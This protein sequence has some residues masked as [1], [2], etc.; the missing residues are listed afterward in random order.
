MGMYIIVRW[1]VAVEREMG[2]QFLVAVMIE[3][4]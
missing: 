2:H 3:V 1:G 4:T